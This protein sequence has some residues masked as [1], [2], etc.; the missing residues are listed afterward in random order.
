ML[1]RRAMGALE[2]AGMSPK[3]ARLTFEAVL[4]QIDVRDILNSVR[5]PTL[6]LHR[7]DEAIPVEFARE[8]AARIP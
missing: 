3:M 7:R 1:L 8:I 4:T 5:V 6:V 2:R